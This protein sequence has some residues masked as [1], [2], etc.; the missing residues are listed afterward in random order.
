MYIKKCDVKEAW[1]SDD[2]LT[3]FMVENH[4]FIEL[5]RNYKQC[6]TILVF[7][8]L[9]SFVDITERD[10]HLKQKAI[11]EPSGHLNDMCML[12]VWNMWNF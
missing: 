7:P 12:N 11:K 5:E 1:N 3:V 10:P 6:K 2:Y 4:M 8:L 9:Q